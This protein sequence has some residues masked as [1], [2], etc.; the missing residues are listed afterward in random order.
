ML[1]DICGSNND[2]SI[3]LL[4]YFNP[5]GSHPLF[6]LGDEPTTDIPKNIMPSIIKVGKG[7]KNILI[8]LEMII[9]LQMVLGLEI[10]FILW[11]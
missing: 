2:W 1:E 6:W 11:I 7:L 5:V 10:I 8:S 4:E 3:T 9:I